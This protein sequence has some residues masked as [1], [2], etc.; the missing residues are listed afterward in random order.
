MVT[1]APAAKHIHKEEIRG[2]KGY[3]KC[4]Q[5][6][7]YFDNGFKIIQEGD[8]NYKDQPV[9][10]SSPSVTKNSLSSTE[11]TDLVTKNTGNITSQPVTK[12]S[13]KLTNSLTKEKHK[14]GDTHKRHEFIEKNK[15]QIIIDLATLGEKKT[16][17]KW[18]ISESG[19]FTIR[20]QWGLTRLTKPKESKGIGVNKEFEKALPRPKEE[21]PAEDPQPS[22]LPSSLLAENAVSLTFSWKFLHDIDDDQ[23]N[24]VW[25]AIG[26]I[27]RVKA[28]R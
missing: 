21:K 9:T 25:N 2:N 7:E 19:W 1:A 8:P 10:F 11:K 5:I 17:A 13:E 14:G 3:Y 15:D 20:K 12:T 22:N 26:I 18:N 4:G 27:I 6:K 16:L 24:R 28:G 23:Y